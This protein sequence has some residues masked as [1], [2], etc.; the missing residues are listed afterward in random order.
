LS[1][2]AHKAETVQG[3]VVTPLVDLGVARADLNEMRAFTNN[4]LLE[5][6]AAGKQE[7]EEKSDAN[8][9]DVDERLADVASSLVPAP[10]RQLF[11]ALSEARGD[12]DTVRDRALELS[13]AGR[14]DDAYAFN[15]AEVVPAFDAVAS[16]F[17]ALY[18]DKIAI[19]ERTSADITST[20]HSRR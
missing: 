11:A 15:K 20:Y 1:S 17:D 14:E 7:A 13:D 8:T 19:G 4:H 10:E 16:A 6:S 2:V 3:N 18:D 9:K 5:P 12:Y